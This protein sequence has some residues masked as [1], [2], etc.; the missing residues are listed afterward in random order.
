[1]TRQD[2]ERA[3]MIVSGAHSKVIP[4]TGMTLASAKLDRI[5]GYIAADGDIARYGNYLR[6]QVSALVQNGK[7]RGVSMD[8]FHSY[9]TA[10]VE[11]MPYTRQ[12]KRA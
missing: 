5:Y 6:A 8:V 11:T 7:E 10:L 9:Q 4:E 1:M 2:R 3:L 12:A